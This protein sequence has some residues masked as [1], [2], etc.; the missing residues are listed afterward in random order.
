MPNNIA[1]TCRTTPHDI[2]ERNAARQP[3]EPASRLHYFDW[4]R[5]IAVLGVVVYHTI[6]PF[7]GRWLISNAETS[8]L[9]HVLALLF[10][11]FGLAVLFLIAG[12]GVRLALEHRSMRA[13]I[14]ERARR[15]LLPFAVGSVVLIPPIYYIIG[16]F[17]GTL[18]VSFPEF[19]LA[20]PVI[21][22]TFWVTQVGLSPQ[23]FIWISMHLWFLA[24]L[25]ICSALAL[26]IF[27]LLSSSVGRSWVGALAHLARR[28]GATLLLA[29]PIALARLGLAALSTAGNTWGLDV[30][31]WYGIVFV[32][33]YVLYSDDRFVAAIRRDLWL[34][35]IVAVVGSSVLLAAGYV[36]WAA[37][38]KT[39]S[40]MDL[41]LM[42]LVGITGWAWTLA[43]LG[44][45]MRAGFMQQPLPTALGETALPVYILH[46]PILFSIAALVIRQ[47]LGL[48]AKVLVNTAMVVAASLLVAA[49]ALRMP[50][51]RPLLGLRPSRYKD[52]PAMGSRLASFRSSG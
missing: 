11:T 22:W 24:W 18:S 2:G 8:D 17:S 25:F 43:V 52:N 15:L 32:L 48:E 20:Y 7:A 1:T 5:A 19:L 4:L 21:A 30:F 42:S 34:A 16:L 38:P 14:A 35:L 39:I 28:P 36:R 51:F 12:A 50:A 47:P 9:L 10:E 45:G 27:A 3:P 37:A 26:P 40:V 49:V 41:I 13:F 44:W 31:A 46:Y 29:L 33:G 23:I 6:L